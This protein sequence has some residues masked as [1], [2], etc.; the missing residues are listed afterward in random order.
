MREAKGAKY[1]GLHNLIL[2]GIGGWLWCVVRLGRFSVLSFNSSSQPVSTPDCRQFG[3][4]CG[5]LAVAR[6][7][8]GW[9]TAGELS[10]VLFAS[11]VSKSETFSMQNET[12]STLITRGLAVLGLLFGLFYLLVLAKYGADTLSLA[13]ALFVMSFSW[14]LFA[15]RRWASVA[16]CVW[17]LWWALWVVRSVVGMRGEGYFD[18]FTNIIIPAVTVAL[19]V[20]TLRAWP[21]LK[22]GL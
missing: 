5:S 6:V 12:S 8:F 21:Q 10:V 16:A 13:F 7:D 2:A 22:A 20:H 11:G 15:L 14:R 3:S 9:A 18:P 1:L 4:L 19:V 17:M